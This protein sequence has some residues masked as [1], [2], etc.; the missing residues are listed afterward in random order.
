MT[1]KELEE[2][3]GL[4]RANI[5]FYE[6]EDLLSPQRRE[7]GYRDYSGNDLTTLLRIKLLRQLDVPLEEI[8]QLIRGEAPLSALMARHAEILAGESQRLTAAREVC[9]EIR[10]SGLSYSSLNPDPYLRRLSQ[11]PAPSK[12]AGTADRPKPCPWRRYFARYLDLGL[13][14]TT[15]TLIAL[16]FFRRLDL[17]TGL[18]WQILFTILGLGT[19]LLVEPLLLS[20]WGTT[21]GKWLLG[22]RVEAWG[23]GLLTYD[24]AFGRTMEVIWQGMGAEIPIYSLFR[25]YHSCNECTNS[26]A[27][28]PWETEGAVVAQKQRPLHI[29]RFVAVNAVQPA[30]LLLA[31]LS[32]LLAPNRGAL[33]RVDYVENYNYYMDMADAAYHLTEEGRLEYR[34]GGGTVF[35]LS[36]PEEY[37]QFTFQ[38]EGGIVTAITVNYDY[39][40][41]R[42]GQGQPAYS[43]SGGTGHMVFLYDTGFEAAFLAAAGA[44]APLSSSLDLL[45]FVDKMTGEQYSFT[46]CGVSMDYL[47]TRSGYQLLQEGRYFSEHP[48]EHSFVSARLTIA[49]PQ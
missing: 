29:I 31:A 6:Q 37:V 4:S 24:A 18:G 39:R 32:L 8:R 35:S 25:L 43:A 49:L 26:G 12:S 40:C 3:T 10:R 47:C 9:E 45:T 5:R 46:F 16:L 21:P 15:C 38:E 1:V 48:N 7:N 27:P 13:Y 2:R 23:G 41:G 17:I 42:A 30:V 11:A 28:L 22:L 19:M 36:E 44:S 14:T 34:S 20:R 33:T